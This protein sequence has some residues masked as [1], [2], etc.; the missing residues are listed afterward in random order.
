MIDIWTLTIFG[1]V[2][3]S[4]FIGRLRKSSTALYILMG[5][6]IGDASYTSQVE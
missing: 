3:K 1:I 2:F 5:C 4:L 6:L